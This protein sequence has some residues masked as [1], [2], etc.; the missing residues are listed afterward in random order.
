MPHSD[1]LAPERQTPTPASCIEKAEARI[2]A[3]LRSNPAE[4]EVPDLAEALEALKMARLGLNPPIISERRTEM[5]LTHSVASY[6][7]VDGEIADC[8]IVDLSSGG[9]MILLDRD[10]NIGDEIM[11]SIPLGEA[12][13]A[14][15]I[16]CVDHCARLRFTSL[17]NDCAE[18]I[19]R[20]AWSKMAG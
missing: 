1:K 20:M 2:A 7:L 8:E 9:A 3:V 10:L 6:F 17:P 18:S 14:A 16:S 12:L 5:R 13:N 11:L 15:V 4:G 19:R